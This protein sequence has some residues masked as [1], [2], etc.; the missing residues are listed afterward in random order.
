MPRVAISLGTSSNPGPYGYDGPG[1]LINAYAE[2]R[3]AEGRVPFP[4]Y[5]IEG[6]EALATLTGGAGVRAILA[7]ESYAIVVAGR[8]VFQVDEAGT[9]TVLGGLPSDG[10]VYLA[11]NRRSPNPQVA[12]V[13]DG[14]YLIA[15]GGVLTTVSD[16]DL[17]P[18]SSV[19]C[20]DG[21]FVFSCSLGRM[22]ASGVDD[23]ETI[24]ALDF[25]TAETSAD[26][27]RCVARRGRELVAVGEA[28]IEFWS[29]TGE[30]NFPF[31]RGQSVEIG[32]LAGKTVQPIKQTLVFVSNQQDVRILN[33]YTPEVIS[34]NAVNRFIR[35]TT[36]KSTL[37]ATSWASAGREFYALSSPSGTWVFDASTG[38]WHERKSHGQ[39]RWRVSVVERLGDTLLAGDASTTSLYAMRPDV[40]AEGSDPIEW[41]IRAPMVH[42]FPSRMIMNA[43]HVDAIPGVGLNTSD[44][45][46]E[47]P[48]IMLDTSEDG[49]DTFGGERQI[50]VGTINQKLTT[51]SAYRLGL[52][53]ATGRVIRLRMSADVVRGL[54][55]ASAD[56]TRLG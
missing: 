33:G 38:F 30:T 31:S 43:L 44:D 26:A 47:T 35:D 9:A 52:I 17:P 32:C 56:L 10:P 49:G 36:D 39:D 54:M 48:R 20:I 18:P 29:N 2:S 22:Y 24:E 55:S 41:E 50:S 28:S 40:Y 4:L 21:Y 16:S 3:G 42:A 25:A 19:V 8:L 6:L 15:S 1:R 53:R 7:L 51:V 37:F 23:G 11:R 34:N 5:V 46:N 12:I 14:T 27:L 45:D 13:C